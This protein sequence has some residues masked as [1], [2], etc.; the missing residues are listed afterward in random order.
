MIPALI[1]AANLAADLTQ[2]AGLPG[3]P[4]LVSAA[5]VT[6]DD[7]P[8]LTIENRSAFDPTDAKRRAVLVGPASVEMVRWFKTSAPR[9]LRDRWAVS[10]LPSA[11]GLD[12][13]SKQRWIVFQAADVVV[14]AVEGRSLAEELRTAPAARSSERETMVARIARE[15]LAIAKLLAARYPDTP[16]ISYIP[17]VSW[18]NTLRLASV[19]KDASLRARVDQQTQPWRTGGKD[20]FGPRVQLTSVAGT[21]VFGELGA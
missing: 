10:A 20:L 14:D 12:G 5:G 18:S 11:D 1:L 17:S 6:K 16:S 3:E 21:F 2:I 8:I 15:P 13:A 7:Q 19:T 4:S 9:E